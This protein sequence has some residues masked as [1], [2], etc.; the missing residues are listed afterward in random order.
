MRYRNP[1]HKLMTTVTGFILIS[2]AS[3]YGQSSVN[4]DPIA[5]LPPKDSIKLSQVISKTE[6]RPGFYA[7]KS[8]SFSDGQYEVIYFMD[9]GAE[10]RLN[11]DAKTGTARPP[12][13]G[14][15]FGG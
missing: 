11:Y 5:T 12:K 9:D 6:E 10:V 4:K 3:A 7:I 14:G 15:L 2:V 1:S 8:V 13:S